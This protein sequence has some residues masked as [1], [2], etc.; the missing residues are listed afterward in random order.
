MKKT[1][2]K[3]SYLATIKVLGKKYEA[4]G[5]T[6]LEAIEKLKVGQVVKGVSVLEVSNGE[7]RKSKIL[8]GPQTFRLFSVSPMM[9][10]V[11]IKNVSLMFQG[12]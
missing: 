7:V 2:R 11:A 3:A 10:D 4:K 8:S 1:T 6:A 12:L 5:A 9:R